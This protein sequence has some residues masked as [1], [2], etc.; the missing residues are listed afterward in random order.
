MPPPLP[1]NKGRRLRSGLLIVF[2]P[3]ACIAVFGTC[4]ARVMP[5][6]TSSPW[7]AEQANRSWRIRDRV[8]ESA[9]LVCL[10]TQ[11]GVK[12][13]DYALRFHASRRDC[14][15]YVRKVVSRHPDAW[16][17]TVIRYDAEYPTPPH[18]YFRDLNL[19][20]FD[21]HTITNGIRFDYDWSKKRGYP[22]IYQS[23][24]ID[25]DKDTV[26]QFVGD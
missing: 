23:I 8:P 17:E 14:D 4:V 12:S 25:T 10:F 5:F 16:A 2:V 18:A 15:S 11:G 22:S 24:W 21:I 1:R 9:S 19:K 3:L 13:F 20:W 6:M 26:Y 7:T